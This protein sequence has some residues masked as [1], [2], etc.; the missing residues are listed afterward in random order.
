VTDVIKLSIALLVPWSAGFAA[1]LCFP[2]PSFRPKVLLTLALSYGLG[3]GILSQW[4][5]I[6][7]IMRIPFMTSTITLP[8]AIL[9]LGACYFRKKNIA[10]WFLPSQ[11]KGK[12]RESQ[13]SPTGESWAKKIIYLL[14][15]AYVS[16]T[17]V[18]V[19]WRAFNIPI[20]T[21]DAVSTSAFKAKVF[22]YEKGL[23]QQAA[24][25]KASYPL[26]TSF[27]MTWTALNLGHWDEILV[28]IFFPLT[29][30]FYLVIQYHFVLSL[31][32]RVWAWVSLALLLSSNLFVYHATIA[33]RDLSVLFYNCTTVLLLLWW[34]KNKDMTFLLLAGFFSGFTTFIKLE[35]TAYWIIHV[36][37][38]LLILMR[39]FAEFRSRIIPTVMS[40]FLPS[41]GICVL[42]YLYKVMNRIAVDQ[43][44]FHLA[45]GQN[46]GARLGTI[47]HEYLTNMFLSGNWGLVWLLLLVS[48]VKIKDSLK[49]KELTYLLLSL[50]A[51]LLLYFIVTLVSTNFISL[52]GEES[53][54]VLSRIL[55][56]FFPLA[57]ISI[58][59][60]NA[61][62]NEPR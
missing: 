40:F 7:G 19:F 26:H 34:L 29:C 27:L 16:V 1:L 11:G 8:L 44:R 10:H 22:F 61:P 39:N 62:R 49:R 48:F 56:H 38:F 24:L 58:I 60:L 35:A 15:V 2:L 4:M 30:F 12:H 5:L 31:T 20:V 54:T 6:L 23:Y 21:W 47:A 51:Y 36:A 9:P 18:A 28:K 33:Y 14:L 41:G 55:L 46:I 13:L 52:A 32:Q 53:P 37:I 57:V 42:Y 17:V 59:L 3:L 45:L 43:G 50:G 25:P